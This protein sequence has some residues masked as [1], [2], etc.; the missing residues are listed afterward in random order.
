MRI[1]TGILSGIGPCAE[2]NGIGLCA[3]PSGI[4]PH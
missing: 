3:E 1:R 4:G 2:P